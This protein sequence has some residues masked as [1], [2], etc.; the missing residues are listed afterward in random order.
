[1]IRAF[2]PGRSATLKPRRTAAALAAAGLCL[3]LGACAVG[4]DYVKPV[5]DVGQGYKEARENV[6][7]WQPAKPGMADFQGRWW[8]VYQDPVL[9]DLMVRLNAS[10]QTIAAAEANYRQA[11]A[12]LRNARSALFPTVG[13]DAGLTRSGSGRG[14]GGSNNSSLSGSGFSSSGGS[15][16]SNEYS[17]TGSVSWEAD[18]WGKVRRGV[19]AS[20]AGTEASAGDLA[21]TRLSAQS[22]LAQNYFSLR[23]ADEQKRLLDATVQTYTQSLTLTQNRY[24]A[25]VAGRAD[26]AIAQ[27]QLENARAASLDIDWQRGQFEHAIAALVGAPPSGFAIAVTT[28]MA[29]V[30]DVPAGLPSQLL[31]RRPDV[32]AAERRAAQANAEIGVAESAWF[33]DLTLSAGGGF[34]GAEFAQWLTAP[35]RFW[36]LGPAL[37]VTLIDGGARSA[38]VDAARAAYDSQAATYRQA[39]L[40]A[41]RE[42]E[43]YLIKLRVLNQEQSVREAALQSARLSLSLA[44]NQY[45]AG[46]IDYLSV[47][48]LQ[49]TSLNTENTAL[50]VV[51]DRLNASVLLMAALGGGWDGQLSPPT[52]AKASP[53]VP[54]AAR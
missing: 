54:E 15:N 51:G 35:A 2:P 10:N 24:A 8:Q 6:P 53:P 14:S 16:V 21:G 46:L 44:V 1:M 47:A 5:F 30:P 40:D 29:R 7:G 9:D 23:I 42:V 18:V 20:R 32:A 36:S 48:T 11:Q 19:E 49:A 3:L 22:T 52:P 13:L 28:D 33:P 37:A 17:L 25:G 43:D 50:Q 34:R 39:A 12:T 45:K 27:T 31:E 4:P 41:L 38:Q 26:I